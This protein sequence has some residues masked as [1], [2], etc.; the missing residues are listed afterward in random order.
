[1]YGTDIPLGVTRTPTSRAWQMAVLFSESSARSAPSRMKLSV[2]SC[3][4]G[5]RELAEARKTFTATG[6]F[7]S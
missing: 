6:R 2:S 5:R 7:H 3:L 1:M 4:A